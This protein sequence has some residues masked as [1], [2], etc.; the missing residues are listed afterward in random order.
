MSSWGVKRKGKGTEF[1]NIKLCTAVMHMYL[2][3]KVNMP[4]YFRAKLSQFM[5]GVKRTAEQ[6]IHKRGG[7]C[8]S[9]GSNRIFWD[10]LMV[11]PLINLRTSKILRIFWIGYISVY[12]AHAVMPQHIVGWVST[13]PVTGHFLTPLPLGEHP[14]P[15]TP[16]NV[17]IL[18]YIG[19][20]PNSL[21]FFH[22]LYESQSN[23]WSRIW[24]SSKYTCMV[25]LPF[26]CMHVIFC[27]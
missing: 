5:S 15:I 13:I 21:S 27:T 10:L 9:E 23:C 19:D 17:S 6:D 7:P 16:V 18:R 3:I 22:S 12:L 14:F 26:Q 24:I 25:F 4:E 20:H 2:T 11:R 1:F 8:V